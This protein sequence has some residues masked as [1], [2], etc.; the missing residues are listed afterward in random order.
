ME[1][2]IGDVVR[3]KSTSRHYGFNKINPKD[4]DGEI[5][6][7]V[8]CG[9]YKYEVKWDSNPV[10]WNYYRLED[11]ALVTPKSNIMVRVSTKVEKQEE[12]KIVH[13]KRRMLVG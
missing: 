4:V 10:V 9:D 11:L 7:F 3:I 13:K 2:N 1:L 5:V 8:D 6:G 12:I